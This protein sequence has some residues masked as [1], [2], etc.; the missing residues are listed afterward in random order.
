V[1]V[2][3]VWHDPPDGRV[4]RTRDLRAAENGRALLGDLQ[5]DLTQR[6]R[7][8]SGPAFQ[9]GALTTLGQF[10]DEEWETRELARRPAN[11]RANYGYSFGKWV[12]PY[13]GG[14]SLEEIVQ[15]GTQI[16]HQWIDAMQKDEAGVATITYAISVAKSVLS[17]AIEWEWVVASQNPLRYVRAPEPSF[18]EEVE[19][20]LEIE[21][22]CLIAW[23]TPTLG[24]VLWAE[25]IGTEALRQQEIVALRLSDLFHQDGT[26]LDRL[27]V[28]K[29]VSGKGRHRHVK[30]LKGGEGRRSPEFFPS[31]AALARAY[32][33]NEHPDSRDPSAR[34]FPADSW[35][36][37]RDMDN[38]RDD[39]WEPALRR[40]GIEQDGRYGHVT[41]HRLRGAAASAYGYARWKEAELLTHVGHKHFTTS[42]QWYI[43][44][45]E[46]PAPELRGMA[47]D[48]QIARARRLTFLRLQD[49]VAF[50]EGESYGE[51][52]AHA[53]GAFDAAEIAL[54]RAKSEPAIPAGLRAAEFRARVWKVQA[55]R[56]RES[57]RAL[58][59]LGS[60]EQL[61][62]DLGP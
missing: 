16:G 60:L 27:K 48:E 22:V 49:H 3:E 47:P 53:D 5:L 4:G 7:R 19:F 46:N 43:R 41:P 29:A 55:R 44:A 28:T 8:S 17:D 42:L 45:Y 15:R 2:E 51:V 54:E 32:V 1:T 56:S 61:L 6:L 24:D 26:P 25:L 18:L 33:D 40:A 31:V 21:H 11:T 50:V 13:L 52:E 9:R 35:D 20:A 30:E 36:G 58:R 62:A 39:V 12:R 57:P 38:W 23:M 34:L 59:M 14:L 37:I 10:W